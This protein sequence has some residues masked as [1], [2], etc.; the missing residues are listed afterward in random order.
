MRVSALETKSLCGTAGGC[1][2]AAGSACTSGVFA[3]FDVTVCATVTSFFV[4]AVVATAAGFCAGVVVE[5]VLSAV[6]VG[7]TVADGNGDKCWVGREYN[8]NTLK[9][10][11]NGVSKIEN[12]VHRGKMLRLTSLLSHSFCAVNIAT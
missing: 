12:I 4:T 11:S 3:G 6:V 9:S 2:S 1:C 8:P 5:V 7:R 10:I